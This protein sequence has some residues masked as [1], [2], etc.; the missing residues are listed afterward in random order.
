MTKFESRI[1][2][3]N[4]SGEK[5]FD[6]LSDFRNFSRF[7]PADKIKEWEAS[8]EQCKFTV[9]GVGKVG[10]KI[11]EKEPNKLV[12]ITGDSTAGLEFFFWIQIKEIGEKDTR[13]KLTIKADLNPMMKMVAAKPL[14]SFVNLMIDKIEEYQFD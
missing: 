10:L 8:T 13:V 14:K 5:A 11:I 2:K 1:G 7:I 3:L 9:E 12:K 6:F 4:T